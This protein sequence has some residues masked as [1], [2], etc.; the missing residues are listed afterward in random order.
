LIDDEE[1]PGMSEQNMTSARRLLEEVWTEG[2]LSQLAE[3]MTEDAVTRPMP[4]TDALHGLEEYRQFIA[5]YKGIFL[6]MRFL[7]ED[8]IASGDKV[9]TRWV[10][11]VT[12][13]SEDELLDEETGEPLAIDGITITHHDANGKIVG[14]WAVW[15]THSLLRTAAAPRIFEQLS[16]VV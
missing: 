6:D 4:H 5:V 2:N 13:D 14:E 12:G 1:I 15:D 10:A 16:I 8:Q 11:I 3:V 9:A 7:I